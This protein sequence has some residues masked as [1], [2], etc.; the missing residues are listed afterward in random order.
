MQTRPLTYFTFWVNYQ[1]GGR[2]PV[3]YH[4]VNIAL[5]LLA[6]WLLWR[7]LDRL[8]NSRAGELYL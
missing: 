2:N 4:I 5:H 7:T 6:V 3:G 1:L 8:V